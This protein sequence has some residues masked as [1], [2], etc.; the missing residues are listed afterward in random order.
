MKGNGTSS[1]DFQRRCKKRGAWLWKCGRFRKDKSQLAFSGGILL[2]RF[3]L[4]TFSV[5][6]SVINF[7]I[8]SLL[9][10]LL[11]RHPTVDI[12]MATFQ[13]FLGPL[14]DEQSF[15]S[16]NDSR[17]TNCAESLQWKTMFSF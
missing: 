4:P 9:L 2:G 3:A 10:K 1:N 14:C 7:T 15:V 12:R 6:N 16:E 13:A 8:F 11:H 5:C 17:M